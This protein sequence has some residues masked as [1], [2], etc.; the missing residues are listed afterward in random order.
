MIKTLVSYFEPASEALHSPKV[1]SSGIK[2][3]SRRLKICARKAGDIANTLQ[4]GN[5]IPNKA[6]YVVALYCMQLGVILEPSESKATPLYPPM[7]RKL[8]CRSDFRRLK[9]KAGALREMRFATIRHG[10]ELTSRYQNAP[11]KRTN[12]FA[13]LTKADPDCPKERSGVFHG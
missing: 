13:L 7:R 4:G 10:A 5:H 11:G 2:P 9:L 3:L 1:H 6:E 8:W 12:P